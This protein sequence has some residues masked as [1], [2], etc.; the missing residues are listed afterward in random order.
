MRPLVIVPTYNERANLAPLVEQLLA[1]PDLRV[2]IVDD[3][4]PD[5]T[6]QIA[7]AYAAANRARV[8]VLH[9]TGK[10]GLGLSYIDGMYVALR[11]DATHIC[12]MDADLSHNP[13]D[14]PRLLHAAEQADFVIGS[15]YVAGG[16]IE[17]WPLHRRMLSAFANRY[18]RAI[19]RLAIRDCTSGFRCWRREALERLPL[20]SIRSDGYAFIVELAW[21]ASR[22]GLR[23]AEVP[24]TFVERR[25]GA[26]KL[27]SGV[28]IESAIVPWRLA[29]RPK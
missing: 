2:L 12:Q 8:Q 13:A 10:R 9:R 24:I 7:D 22:A 5:G 19:T 1:I 11:T 29:A 15:R 4:S 3:A 18:I 26:S 27:S 14:V 17:N 21:E 16:R 6:G 20:A 25:E 23:C 28:I